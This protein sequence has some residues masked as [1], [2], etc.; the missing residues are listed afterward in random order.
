MIETELISFSHSSLLTY[1]P[2]PPPRQ[3][4]LPSS[5]PS[6]LPCLPSIYLLA[7]SVSRALPDRTGEELGSRI[8]T[9]LGKFNSR[10]V[11]QAGST[12]HP[13]I[14]LL[15]S[16]PW[17]KSIPGQCDNRD[18]RHVPPPLLLAFNTQCGER[19]SQFLGGVRSWV[20]GTSMTGGFQWVKSRTMSQPGSTAR[21]S[22][23]PFRPP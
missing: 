13:A 19:G 1:P 20:K 5:S 15:P 16:I 10:T 6:L 17:A 3:P 23:P 11:L 14:P 12:V 7:D 18:Q 2:S 22:A 9:A 21:R 8:E 4:P